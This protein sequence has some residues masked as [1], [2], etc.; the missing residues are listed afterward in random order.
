MN[1]QNLTIGGI[2]IAVAV[3]AVAF[4]L[5]RGSEGP[6]GDQVP[7]ITGPERA[8][9]ARGVIAEIEQSRARAAAEGSP[10]QSPPSQAGD[11]AGGGAGAAT[12]ATQRER[13]GGDADFDTAFAQAQQFQ[14]SGQLADA[15]LL[16]FYG[17]RG[18]HAPSAFALGTMND[19]NHHSPDI[20]LLPEPDAFQAFRWYSSA[21]EQGM[22]E[23]VERLDALREW[24]VTAASTGDIDAEQL[25]LQWE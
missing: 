3:A 18:G 11:A 6:T 1:R 24:A 4:L 22:A 21:R 16:Y 10:P 23:A 2:A 20:S 12:T 9:E 19:P 5:F 25:L 17:A 15:Q 14:R 8:E 13:P 7:A